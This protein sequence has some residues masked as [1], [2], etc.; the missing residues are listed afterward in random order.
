[1]RIISGRLGGRNFDAPRTPRTHPMSERMRGAM[2]NALGDIQGLS[3][4]D[5]FGGSGALSIEA[6]SRGADRSVV[7]EVDKTAFNTIKT[8]LAKLALEDSIKAIKANVSAWSDN[9]ETAAFD[10]VLCNPPF[11]KLKPDLIQKLTRHINP[12][13]ILVLSWPTIDTV[14]E[15]SGLHLE[16]IKE[17]DYGDAQLVFYRKT[18]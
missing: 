17:K 3:V 2:F 7:V 14:P 11:D 4:L 16:S 9:N 1:M 13:G 6:V 10:L 15:I 18:P 12:G 5:A 8:N